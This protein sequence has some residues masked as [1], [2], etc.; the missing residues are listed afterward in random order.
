M[1]PSYPTE[2]F[3]DSS[4]VSY[5]Q[6]SSDPLCREGGSVGR[7]HQLPQ[8]GGPALPDCSPCAQTPSHVQVIVCASDPLAIDWKLQRLCPWVQLICNSG[9]QNPEKYFTH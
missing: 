8:V 9:S 5:N 6:L 1:S 7:Q 4:R 3:S 2:Q